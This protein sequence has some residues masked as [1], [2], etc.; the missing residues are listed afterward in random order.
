[1]E[2]VIYKPYK[3]KL[4]SWNYDEDKSRIEEDSNRYIISVQIGEKQIVDEETGEKISSEELVEE[5]YLDSLQ[6]IFLNNQGYDVTV[7]LGYEPKIVIAFEGRLVMHNDKIPVYED[8]VM[9]MLKKT[10]I[11][12]IVQALVDFIITENCGEKYSELLRH[13]QKA[14]NDACKTNYPPEFIAHVIKD[15]IGEVKRDISDEQMEYVCMTYDE[16]LKV[17]GEVLI[18]K[19]QGKEDPREEYL[20]DELFYRFLQGNLIQKG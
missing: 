2:K 1:M 12:P 19:H 8:Q 17:A 11:A 5:I 3:R 7:T 10:K 14:I 4:S 9:K 15:Y 16:L 18:A 6:G 20:N 13:V